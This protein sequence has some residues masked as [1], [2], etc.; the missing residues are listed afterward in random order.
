MTKSPLPVLKCKTR[1][2]RSVDLRVAWTAISLCCVTTSTLVAVHFHRSFDDHRRSSSS[3]IPV[4]T[5]ASRSA[6]SS[7]RVLLRPP[8]P[9][10]SAAP[11]IGS[12]GLRATEINDARASDR[13][14][15]VDGGYAHREGLAACLLVND[16]NL[17]LNEWIAYHYHVLPLRHLIV[18]VDP[19]SRTSPA[20][21]L[22]RWNSSDELGMDVKI[23]GDDDFRPE[24]KRGPAPEHM[25]DDDKTHYHRDRQRRFIIKC[26]QHFKVE[27]R[28][29]VLL[30][31]VDEYIIFNG[32]RDDD[33][34]TPTDEAPEGVPTLCDWDRLE[35]RNK[36]K[37]VGTLCHT[38][39][40]LR[41]GLKMTTGD[42]VHNTEK[43][44]GT[45]VTDDKGEKYFLRDD[46]TYRDEVALHEAPRGMPT[47]KEY[48][49]QHGGVNGYIYNDGHHKDGKEV[50]IPMLFNENSTF[51][52]GHIMISAKTGRKFYLEREQALWPPHLPVEETLAARRRLPSVGVDGVTILDVIKKESAGESYLGP[53]LSMPRLFYGAAESKADPTWRDMAPDGFEDD[54]FVTL[55]YRHHAR[56]GVHEWNKYEKVI[57]DVSRIPMDA[58]PAKALNIHRPLFYYCRRDHPRY[59]TSLFRVN[60]YL[61][62]WKAYTYRNDARSSQRQCKECYEEKSSGANAGFD[63]DIRPWLKEFVQ[64]VGRKKATML[65]EGTGKFD[66]LPNV[67]Y[68]EW[69]A[70]FASGEQLAS[71][72]TLC[73]ENY[74]GDLKQLLE[75]GMTA[76]AATVQVDGWTQLDLRQDLKE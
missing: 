69:K 44:P 2:P 60:H 52:G 18:A 61:D 64:S 30:I 31:D 51:H 10:N 8:E 1:W 7:G 41:D 75:M 19:A 53:C 3:H 29:W 20:G 26:M 58:F 76:E 22:S 5:S 11:N 38:G 16:E 9:A 66:A 42:I 35:G 40:P 62:S 65:L 13:D 12:V 55:R 70:P 74:L 36:R 15:V 14:V 23:W 54:R 32:V 56:K 47:L 63:D 50:T 24:G 43:Y 27:G 68:G 67:I 39:D 17:R 4:V 21:I 28:S 33:P 6:A 59:M 49:D 46:V 48:Q 45:V 71:L 73:P 34:V 72:R 37:L 25:K 57:I